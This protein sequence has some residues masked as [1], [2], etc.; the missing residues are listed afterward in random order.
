MRASP[1]RVPPRRS[2]PV[3][4]GVAPTPPATPPTAPPIASGQPSRTSPMTAATTAGTLTAKSARGTSAVARTPTAVPTPTMTPIQY[5]VPTSSQCSDGGFRQ[6]PD[7]IAGRAR[8]AAPAPRGRSGP[9]L[10]ANLAAG[11]VA[12]TRVGRRDVVVRV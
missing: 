1:A 3:T 2:A 7:E 8:A 10:A 11:E 5:Q 12:R 6:P 9:E 4:I